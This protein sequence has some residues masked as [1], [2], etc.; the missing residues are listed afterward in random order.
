MLLTSEYTTR[1]VLH[2]TAKQPQQQHQPAGEAMGWPGIG[3]A[4]DPRTL[5]RSKHAAHHR[6]PRKPLGCRRPIAFRRARSASFLPSKFLAARR[7]SGFCSI[8]LCQLAHALRWK[9]SDERLKLAQNLSW[10]NFVSFSLARRRRRRVQPGAEGVAH[11]LDRAA[12]QPA[13]WVRWRSYLWARRMVR[14]SLADVCARCPWHTS[15]ADV[16]TPAV[17]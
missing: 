13:R 9:H 6:A 15:R 11:G 1:R 16:A 8:K 4:G 5:L 17:R 3:M 7:V 2:R 14:E 12:G 10:A